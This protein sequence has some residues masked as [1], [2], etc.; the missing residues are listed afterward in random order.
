M[1]K[2]NN[3][4]RAT[5]VLPE[6]E[7]VL[8]KITM[9]KP[10]FTYEATEFREVSNDDGSYTIYVR[11][12]E[13]VCD[14]ERVGE[15]TYTNGEGRNGDPAYL[16]ESLHIRKE[17]GRRNTQVTSDANVAVKT[18]LKYFAPPPMQKVCTDLVKTTIDRLETIC[19]RLR[20]NLGE[21]VSYEG[22]EIMEYFIER[23]MLNMQPQLPKSLVLRKDK[24]FIYERYQV[25]KQIDAH[26]QGDRSNRKGYCV[27]FL[28]DESIRVVHIGYKTTRSHEENVALGMT[29]DRYRTFDALPTEKL[30]NNIAML[31]IAE[32]GDPYA[33][34]GVKLTE[35]LMYIME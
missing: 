9:K 30:K 2:V 23:E 10:L 19:Y 26:F 16:V 5:K 4:G 35:D 21:V 3:M 15:I 13:V 34:I 8:D 31:K 18:A 7:F 29:I 33:D 6:L 20:T 14:A 25:G 27:S 28:P 12:V 17:R 11:G 32:I 1:A 22:K 24:M